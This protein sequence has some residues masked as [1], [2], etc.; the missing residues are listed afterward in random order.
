MEL[1]Q[2]KYF[3]A[4]A[5]EGSF[6]AA[7]KASRVSQPSL[8]SQ[9]A[10]LEAEL[11]GPLL[12]RSRQGAR[13][14]QRGELFRGRAA[15]ALRQL[16]SGRF[17]LAE[18]S[19]LKRGSVSLGCLPTTGAYLLPP[20]LKAFGRA[21]PG[22][23]VRLREESSPGLAKALRESEVDLAIMDEAGLGQGI[24]AD[25]LFSEPL[26]IALP[27]GHRFAKRKS[28]ALKALEGEPLILMKSG[29]GFRKIVLD[30]LA[31]AG[32]EP[33]VVHESGEIETVQ[34]LV[35]AGLG[36]S[37]VPSM[38]RRAG[39]AYLEILPPRPSR[40]LLIAWRGDSALSPAAQALKAAAERC[41]SRL[42]P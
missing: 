35:Q 22:I 2:L 37:L 31:K 5:Q 40:S 20:L 12:E 15:E 21:H 25:T 14:T 19:G 1:Q 11:G 4:V 30:A 33:K 42:K 39:I 29:H 36:L 27:R 18:L 3:L 23:S 24:R 26:L 6:T 28:M 34:A 41:F 32:V 7:A 17:E 10:K 13:L 16:E 8:S 9:V 38:V